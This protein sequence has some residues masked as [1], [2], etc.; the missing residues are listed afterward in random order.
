MWP[1][2]NPSPFLGSHDP[3]SGLVGL[4]D[5]TT[6]VLWT[7][8]SYLCSGPS[9]KLQGPRERLRPKERECE[10]RSEVVNGRR[11][12]ALYPG[13]IGVASPCLFRCRIH[14]LGHSFNSIYRASGAT[15]SE[16]ECYDFWM[17]AL[18]VAVDLSQKPRLKPWVSPLVVTWGCAVISAPRDS[19]SCKMGVLSPSSKW[20]KGLSEIQDVKLLVQCQAHSRY[21]KNYRKEHHVLQFEYQL[22]HLPVIWS[23]ASDW[24]LWG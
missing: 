6:N 2:A 1:Q 23:Q 12:P 18:L 15:G 14:S 11:F 9:T 21:L 24:S 22:N 17:M 13:P 5:T 19:G 8:I 3:I 7:P 20:L 16:F 4:D 10:L